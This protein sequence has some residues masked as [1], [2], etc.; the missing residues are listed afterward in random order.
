VAQEQTLDETRGEAEQLL[1]PLMTGLEAERAEILRNELDLISGPELAIALGLA[2]QTLASWRSDKQGPD[3]V[4]LGK[5]VFYQRDDLA[6]WIKGC[7]VRLAPVTYRDDT[8]RHP[9]DPNSTAGR[10]TIRDYQSSDPVM[11]PDD[12]KR[13]G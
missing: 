9:Q 12:P 2:E 8:L 1:L 10:V 5:S 11:H 13:F 6:A 4:K 7:R 3:F